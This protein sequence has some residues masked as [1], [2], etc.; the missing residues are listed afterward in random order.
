MMIVYL[1]LSIVT[2]N[3]NEINS[4]TKTHRMPDTDKKQTITRATTTNKANYILSTR[5]LL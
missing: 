2:L 1:F 4:P 5:D 3:V